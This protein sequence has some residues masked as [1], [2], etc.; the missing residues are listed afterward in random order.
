[1]AVGHYQA[2]VKLDPGNARAHNNLGVA[3]SKLGKPDLAEA[4]YRQA[5][6]LQPDYAEAR[7]NLEALQQSGGRFSP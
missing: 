5:I 1:M 4:E 6:K 7:R 3:Y 2:A